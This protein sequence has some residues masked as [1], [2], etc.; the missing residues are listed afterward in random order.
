MSALTDV[1]RR[2]GA[3][4]LAY[5]AVPAPDEFFEAARSLLATD[6]ELVS[7]VK[8]ARHRKKLV[9]DP[10][11]TQNEKARVLAEIWQAVVRASDYDPNTLLLPNNRAAMRGG[12][13]LLM[14]FL[15]AKGLFRRSDPEA[16]KGAQKFL[17]DARRDVTKL[18]RQIHGA[19]NQPPDD[20]AIAWLR[21]AAPLMRQKYPN[22]PAT[23]IAR[24]LFVQAGKE[25]VTRWADSETVRVT[26][27]KNGIPL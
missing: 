17:I 15:V 1:I 19:K 23:S 8:R 7:L 22:A 13:R 24:W 16:L 20:G 21:A 6:P 27:Y 26:A 25:D 4:R 3:A 18:Q 9:T 2:A 5:L 14:A 12:L 11:K 10:V